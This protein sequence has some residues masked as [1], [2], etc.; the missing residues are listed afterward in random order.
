M[1]EPKRSLPAYDQQLSGFHR[2][3]ERELEAIVSQLPLGPTARV[4]DLACGDGFYT[5]RIAE[6][7][8]RAVKGRAN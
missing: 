4:L 8:T 7:G 6:R 2:A 5:R 1:T 3:F